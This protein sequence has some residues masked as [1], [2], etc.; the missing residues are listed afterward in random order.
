M[1]LAQKI[2]INDAGHQVVYENFVPAGCENDKKLQEH[3]MDETSEIVGSLD[4]IH[5]ATGEDPA[6]TGTEQPADNPGASATTTTTT[7]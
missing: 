3:L 5:G 2:V 1:H 4:N 6:A 7:G